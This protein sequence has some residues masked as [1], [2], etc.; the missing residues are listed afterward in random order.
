LVLCLA[1]FAKNSSSRLIT[2]NSWRTCTLSS[3]LVGP[4]GPPEINC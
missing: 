2:C 3:R 1:F 4:A